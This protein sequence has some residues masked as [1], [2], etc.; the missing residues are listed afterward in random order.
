MVSTAYLISGLAYKAGRIGGTM[1]LG[2]QGMKM[3]THDRMKR[4]LLSAQ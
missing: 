1:Y 3:G 2:W 4:L